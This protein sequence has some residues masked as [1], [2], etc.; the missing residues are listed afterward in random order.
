MVTVVP[1]YCQQMLRH[2]VLEGLVLVKLVLETVGLVDLFF[3]D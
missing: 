3:S 2:I 1:L